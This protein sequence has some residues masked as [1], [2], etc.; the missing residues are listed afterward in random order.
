M[1]RTRGPGAQHDDRRREIARGVLDVVAAEGLG[2][3]SLSTVAARAGVS[4]G[5]VQHY[6][7]A[8]EALLEAAFDQA[9]ADAAARVTALAGGD[10]A[11]AAP[12]DLLTAVLTELVPYD[13]RTRVHM[14]VRQ[15][16]AALALHH[17][18]IAERLRAEYH[19]L[20]H[21][22]IGGLVRRDQEAGRVPTGLDPDATAVRLVALAEGL[23]Y[24][25]LI[26][27]AEAEAARAEVRAAIAGLYVR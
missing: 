16:F 18:G 27:A 11:T 10:Q 15:A 20:H 12:R 25:V 13:E 26:G 22:D 17:D 24:Y 23:A 19:R 21:D 7:P 6:F 14:R 2:A 4:A 8:K 5:R 9:N 1:P 3:V